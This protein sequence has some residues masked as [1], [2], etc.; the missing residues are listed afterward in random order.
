MEHPVRLVWEHISPSL[1]GTELRVRIKISKA[2]GYQ[3][4]PDCSVQMAVKVVVWLPRL[5]AAEAVGRVLLSYIVWQLSV[6]I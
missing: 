2:D 4:R 3:P 1:V 6:C 5:A